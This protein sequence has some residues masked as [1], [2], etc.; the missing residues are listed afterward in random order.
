[1]FAG[2][3]CVI[4]C[5]CLL[6][7]SIVRSASR[8]YLIY[9]EA[10]FEGFRPA[11]RPAG[12]TRCTNFDARCTKGPLLRAKFHRHRCNDKGVE[13]QKLKFLL[14]FDQNVEYKRPVGAYPL[15]DFHKIC[16]VCTSFQEASG[17]KISLDLLKGYG[18][19]GVLS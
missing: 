6:T 17:V 14:I 4:A 16:R 15:P 18:V 1:M 10:D 9:S 12:V 7:G 13:P 3:K 5:I 11:V 19:M 8:R 2:N